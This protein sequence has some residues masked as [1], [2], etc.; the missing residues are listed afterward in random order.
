MMGISRT[1][2]VLGVV[3]LVAAAL[4]PV[5]ASWDAAPVVSLLVLPVTT[6]LLRLRAGDDPLP[7]SAASHTPVAP[8]APPT[9]SSGN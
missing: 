2:A 8:R 7:P 9:Q 5:T 1:F 6:V 3:L 4:I